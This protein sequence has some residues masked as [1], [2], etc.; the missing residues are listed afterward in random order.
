M[1]KNVLISFAQFCKSIYLISS[2]YK[3][4]YVITIVFKNLEC[5]VFAQLELLDSGIKMFEI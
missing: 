3:E 1:S 2:T 4:K 5:N